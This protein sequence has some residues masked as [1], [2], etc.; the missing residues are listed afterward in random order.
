M[1]NF[2]FRLEAKEETRI[3]VLRENVKIYFQFYKNL[4]TFTNKKGNKLVQLNP[5]S[6]KLTKWSNTLKQFVGCCWPTVWV[7]LTIL[8]GWR[9]KGY[10]RRIL[11][12]K[13]RCTTN[14]Y[15]SNFP[16]FFFP[17][18]KIS[19][20]ELVYISQMLEYFYRN[21]FS[22]STRS[23]VFQFHSTFTVDIISLIHWLCRWCFWSV[24]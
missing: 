12:N 22:T 16:F 24:G 14:L 13:S 1:V 10:F 15:F 2:L 8:W 4:I 17:S 11:D 9:L 7:C 23:N 19:I 21:S 3:R 18:S 20:L 6:A 5:L